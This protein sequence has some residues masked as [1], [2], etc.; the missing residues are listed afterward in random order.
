MVVVIFEVWPADG[1][2]TEYLDLAAELKT[3][4]EKVD[5]FISV[6]R[7]ESLTEKGKLLSLS[8]WRDDAAVRAWRN[9]AEHRVAQAKGRDSVFAGYRLRVASVM[10]D[11]GMDQRAEAPSDSQAVHE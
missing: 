7:Y 9:V 5:G 3:E 4:L 11:Y 2:R 8:T 10:R 6:E 1:H